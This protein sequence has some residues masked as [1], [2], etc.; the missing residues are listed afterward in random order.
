MEPPDAIA[1]AIIGLQAGQIAQ[2]RML[3]ALIASHPR[4]VAL[5]DAWNRFSAPSIA[6]AEASRAIDPARATVHAALARELEDWSRRLA[7]DLG[8]HASPPR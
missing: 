2:A 7:Q 6:N 1:D 5:R 8:K 4:P 3:R